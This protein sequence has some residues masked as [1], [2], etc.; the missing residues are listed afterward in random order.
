MST[1]SSASSGSLRGLGYGKYDVSA[2]MWDFD[3]LLLMSCPSGCRTLSSGFALTL[4]SSGNPHVVFSRRDG[5]VS[6]QYLE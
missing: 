4:D 5:N 1:Q 6:L 2:G 3:P